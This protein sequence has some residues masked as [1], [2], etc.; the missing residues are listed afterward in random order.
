MAHNEPV[1]FLFLKKQ[2][3]KL[4]KIKPQNSLLKYETKWHRENCYESDFIALL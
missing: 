4:L 2:A 1:E 3:Q